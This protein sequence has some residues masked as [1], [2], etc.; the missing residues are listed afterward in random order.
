MLRGPLYQVIRVRHI[1]KDIFSVEDFCVLESC[2][3]YCSFLLQ[4]QDY[5]MTDFIKPCMLLALECRNQ[6][7]GCLCSQ[8]P[9]CH[10]RA[11]EH[12]LHLKRSEVSIR[13]RSCSASIPLKARVLS[14]QVTVKWFTIREFVQKKAIHF[15]LLDSFD[16]FQK[17]YIFQYNVDLIE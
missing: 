15:A 5:F 13:I 1:R 3:S 8:N 16:F 17:P 10:L 2:F 4:T 11:F 7:C 6:G 12:Y 9:Q 14:T